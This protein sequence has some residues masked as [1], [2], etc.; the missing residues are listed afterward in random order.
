MRSSFRTIL[1]K[2]RPFIHANIARSARRSLCSSTRELDLFFREL[3]KA[4]GLESFS[5]QQM[6]K[7]K[8]AAEAK[9]MDLTDKHYQVALLEYARMEE[10]DDNAR[11]VQ[12]GQESFDTKRMMDG[13]AQQ[14]SRRKKAKSLS[15]SPADEPETNMKETM[16]WREAALE[17]MV[18]EE[19]IEERLSLDNAGVKLRHVPTGTFVKCFHSKTD[20]DTNRSK[21][22]KMLGE[23]IKE[24]VVHVRTVENRKRRERRKRIRRVNKLDKAARPAR[25]EEA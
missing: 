6:Q 19:D 21:A 17:A 4:R 5:P 24:L 2:W 11:E 9:G 20:Q 12:T 7:M 18:L 25:G 10:Q 8:T 22:R 3:A 15:S 14:G 16:T 23:R 1:S 13:N